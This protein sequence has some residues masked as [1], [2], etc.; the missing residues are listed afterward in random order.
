MN[1]GG[2]A[3]QE[4]ILWPLA[5][6]C[7]LSTQ[8]R[9]HVLCQDDLLNSEHHLFQSHRKSISADVHSKEPSAV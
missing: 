6:S 2:S 1:C 7:I 3:H 8:T 4:P 9:G 5:R